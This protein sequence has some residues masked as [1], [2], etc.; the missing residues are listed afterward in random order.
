MFDNLFDVFMSPDEGAGAGVTTD[1]N[2]GGQAAGAGEGTQTEPNQQQSQQ[3]QVTTFD[4][5]KHMTKEEASRA[6]QQRVNDLNQRYGRKAT[7]V[8]KLAQ[9]TGWTEDMIDVYLDQ[10]AS[11]V[12]GAPQQQQQQA[13]QIDPALLQ[14]QA[15]A[16]NAAQATL[17]TRRMVEEQAIKTNPLYA[18]FEQ[19]KDQVRQYADQTGL[20]LEQAYWA[21]NGASRAKAIQQEAEQ[22]ALANVNR[23]R[24]LGAEG[25]GAAEFSKL[26]LSAEEIAFAQA[27]GTDPKRFAALKNAT[28]LDSYRKLKQQK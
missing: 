12:G 4:P 22:R 25:D 17:E 1:P 18:D 8:D 2:A 20:S 26:G 3:Q 11:G 5:T 21:V 6:I 19:V 16:K 24:G 10:V 27:T 9:A 14:T 13:H 7:I 28:D 15:L 23:N